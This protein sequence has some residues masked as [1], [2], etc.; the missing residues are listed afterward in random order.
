[1]ATDEKI[2][3]VA[4]AQ[5]ID[6]TD[7]FCM[8]QN[9]A[10]TPLTVGKTGTD[11]KNWLSTQNVQTANYETVDADFGKVIIMNKATAITLTIHAAAVQGFSCAI[12]QKGAGQV[13]IAAAGTGAIRNRSSQTKLAGQYAMASVYV[14]SNAGTAP[15]VYLGG[16]TSA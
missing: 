2:S 5:A 11:L 4:N 10:G 16:D 6:N 8:V 7:L 1:M 3:Q 9:M 13:T 14:E 15:Q 12:L